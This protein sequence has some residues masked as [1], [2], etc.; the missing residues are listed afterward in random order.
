MAVSALRISSRP[1]ACG[2]VT[3]IPMLAWILPPCHDRERR[4]QSLGDSR[5]VLRLGN[6]G[7]P[8]GGELVAAQPGGHVARRIWPR[9]RSATASGARHPRRGLAVVDVL[10]V[11][12]VHEEDCGSSRRLVPRERSVTWP[13]KSTRLGNR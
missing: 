9:R 5:G 10:E 1:A 13:V 3:A 11:V 8:A 6:V 7:S 4:V 12:E 2:P